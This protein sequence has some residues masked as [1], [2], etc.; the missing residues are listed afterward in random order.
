MEVGSGCGQ[1]VHDRCSNEA[2]SMLVDVG[3]EDDNARGLAGT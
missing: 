3:A 2:L 1:I